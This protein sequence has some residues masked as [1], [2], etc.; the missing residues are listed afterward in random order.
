MA[1][2]HTGWE[3]PDSYLEMKTG[4][5]SMFRDFEV[6][7]H[8]RFANIVHYLFI[9]NEYRTAK[10]VDLYCLICSWYSD[11]SLTAVFFFVVDVPA[12]PHTPRVYVR[13][14]NW[15]KTFNVL[16]SNMHV[17]RN[18]HGAFAVFNYFG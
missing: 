3:V 18:V 16:R 4:C 5:R 1:V 9:G 12:A 7:V 8:F 2:L 10:C 14:V 17:Q 13:D 11:K 6:R 15:S